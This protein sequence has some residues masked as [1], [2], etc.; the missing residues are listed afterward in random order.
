MSLQGK[1]EAIIYAAEE[2]VTLEQLAMLLKRDVLAELEA[3]ASATA[4][5]E[6]A[7]EETAA[8]Q[9]TP[10]DH[11]QNQTPDSTP[12]EAPTG[13]STGSKEP[14]E[15]R[16]HPE[17]APESEEPLSMPESLSASV[18][19][20]AAVAPKRKKAVDP[21]LARVKIHL[22]GVMVNVIETY[23][24]DERG[25]EIRQIAGGYRMAT[26]PEHHDLVRTFAKSLKPAIKLSLQALET[27]AIIA[28]KQPVTA[29]EI[30]DIRGVD[31]G[32]VLGTLLDRKLITTAGRKQLRS[33][34]DVFTRYAR[35]VFK[36][37]QVA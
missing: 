24:S 32:G 25:V 37:L 19:T 28:Y 31:S 10:A 20:A 33:Q 16:Q 1:I 13:T 3:Q 35:A 7:P 8:E 29:P 15:A 5:L 23:A 30:A 34:T 27:L 6:F 26:K 11:S 22:R 36:V 2:P 21:E 9:G 18:T 17:R 14:S 4:P 12:P